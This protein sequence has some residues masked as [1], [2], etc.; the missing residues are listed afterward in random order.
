MKTRQPYEI[1]QSRRILA[2][3]TL[4]PALR[5]NLVDLQIA[6]GV[7]EGSGIF[8][9]DDEASAREIIDRIDENDKLVGQLFTPVTRPGDRNY[10]F[11]SKT[12]EEDITRLRECAYWLLNADGV[13]QMEKI[14][15]RRLRI[16]ELVRILIAD[17]QFKDAHIAKFEEVPRL[18]EFGESPYLKLLD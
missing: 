14:I 10:R 17:L 13:R 6:V 9:E 3:D 2:R 4:A 18:P 1:V 7:L 16:Y 11:Q 5:M 15:S 8:E 12:L